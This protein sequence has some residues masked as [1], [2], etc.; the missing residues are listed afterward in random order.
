MDI[1]LHLGLPKTGSTF[2]QSEIFQKTK[3]VNYVFKV[4]IPPVYSERSE[5]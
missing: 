1:I 5:R 2:L 3:D 4:R